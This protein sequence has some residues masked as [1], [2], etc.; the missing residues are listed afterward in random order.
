MNLTAV[1]NSVIKK[2]NHQHKHSSSEMKLT[3]FVQ[4]RSV[5]CVFFIFGQQIQNDVCDWTRNSFKIEF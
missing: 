5:S 1:I 3:E 4:F 2:K